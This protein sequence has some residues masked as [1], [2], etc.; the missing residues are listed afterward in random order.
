MT[1]NQHAILSVTAVVAWINI[2]NT[3]LL[4]DFN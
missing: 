2:F 3:R 4:I 1:I